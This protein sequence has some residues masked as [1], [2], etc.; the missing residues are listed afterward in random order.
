MRGT[1]VK[2]IR[3]MQAQCDHVVDPRK[4]RSSAHIVHWMTCEDC[5]VRL[6]RLRP[7][8]KEAAARYAEELRLAE[9]AILEK[10]RRAARKAANASAA[11][12][13]V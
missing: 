7:M 8:S 3:K 10:Q 9:E 6:D 1:K 2:A 11:R 5:G 12:T 13:D 4:T